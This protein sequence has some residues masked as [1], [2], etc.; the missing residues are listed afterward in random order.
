MSH[1]TVTI[2]G[3]DPEKQLE[4]FAEEA[5]QEY[6]EFNDLEEELKEE[7]E[8]G[9]LSCVRTSD[10]T[11]TFEWNYE[12]DDNEKVKI[13]SIPKKKMYPTFKEYKE[14]F[15]ACEKDPSTGK[16][17]YWHNPNA[18]WDWYSLGGRWQG[19]YTLIETPLYPHKLGRP[20][21]FG[22]S[23]STGLVRKADQCHKHDIDVE[24]M[25]KEAIEYVTEKCIPVFTTID[26][27]GMPPHWEDVRNKYPDDIGK[28]RREYRN[29]KVIRMLRKLRA[30]PVFDSLHDKY[31]LELGTGEE[32]LN[33]CIEDAK[34]NSI[35]TFAV[36]MDG[37]WYER[38]EMGWWGAVSNKKLTYDWSTKFFE[39][40]ESIS[41][42]TMLS[43]YDC[44]I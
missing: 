40:F 25:Y 41:D 16:Y 5:S 3:E 10:G 24:A 6:T 4:P 35:S 30:M 37:K 23:D 28:A 22:S 12:K 7:Y 36:L 43:V 20:G 9:V 18:K 19:F 15:C 21:T 32:A 1:F 14:E 2:I 33:A 26:K 13:I 8:N 39:L 11:L 38:G 34:C 31:H 42:D 44:H 29:I 17:G 27:Y